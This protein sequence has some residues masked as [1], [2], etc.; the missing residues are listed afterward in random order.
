[1]R[2][3]CGRRR[4]ARVDAG[5]GLSSG[6]DSEGTP[7]PPA[8][9]WGYLLPSPMRTWCGLHH[10]LAVAGEVFRF[11]ANRC[12]IRGRGAGPL[13]CRC[14]TR[15]WACTGWPM[16]RWRGRCALCRR[17]CE[18]SARSAHARVGAT[19]PCGHAS[20]LIDIRISGAAGTGPFQCAG[21]LSPTSI[22]SAHAN[23]ARHSTRPRLSRVSRA[24]G[25]WCASLR[26]KVSP[27]SSIA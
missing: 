12:K 21:M 16:Q 10:P 20:A 2:G 9:A 19:A 22:T 27:M 3:R 1:M 13:R 11:G 14:T 5:V 17:A 8:T 15:H 6:P 18:R 24:R 23:G 4:M 7:G 26:E 25:R